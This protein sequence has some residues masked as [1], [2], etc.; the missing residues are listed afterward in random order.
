ML[1]LWKKDSRADSTPRLFYITARTAQHSPEDSKSDEMD[2]LALI[3]SYEARLR[4]RRFDGSGMSHANNLPC[5]TPTL[6]INFNNPSYYCI[7]I[8]Y[9]DDDRR[10]LPRMTGEDRASTSCFPNL[11]GVRIRKVISKSQ[12]NGSVWA[13]S[14]AENIK[15]KGLQTKRYL[16]YCFY[17]C[18][19]VNW[20]TNRRGR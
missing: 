16:S 17:F 6:E 8:R 11:R 2:R 9:P 5:Y 1:S 7:V 3:R 10:L 12:M 13:T 14:L 4:I 20:L 19:A 15:E 18:T